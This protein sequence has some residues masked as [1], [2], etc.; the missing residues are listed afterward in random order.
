MYISRDLFEK[1]QIAVKQGRIRDA[2]NE[3]WIADEAI[4]KNGNIYLTFTDYEEEDDEFME[5]DPCDYERN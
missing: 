4:L 5:E 1:I 3:S 2:E